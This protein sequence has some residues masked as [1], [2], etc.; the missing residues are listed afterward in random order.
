M[1]ILKNKLAPGLMLAVAVQFSVT[2]S[3][4]GQSESAHIPVETLQ[5][6]DTGIG[7]MKAAVA[8]GDMSKGGH[9]TFLKMPKNF[10]SPIH[11]H[12]HE[13]RAVVLSG[14]IVN[15]EVGEKDIVMNPGSFWYQVGNREHVTKC[16]SDNGCMVYLSQPHNFD[17][18]PR[19][20]TA[21]K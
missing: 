13:Y 18:I 8:Y 6:F 19:K 14:Q 11:K 17:F 2:A 5:W 7:P 21:S 20:K 10:S 1:D 12:T 16:V 15:S 4:G 9:G 3:A